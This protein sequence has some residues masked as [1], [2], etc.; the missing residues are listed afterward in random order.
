MSRLGIAKVQNLENYKER[1][2]QTKT[3]LNFRADK[4]LKL[5]VYTLIFIT[6][7]LSYILRGVRGKMSDGTE[8][9][10]MEDG[11][12]VYGIRVGTI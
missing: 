12:F 7:F 5:P 9:A 11:L 4:M 10:S 2:Q 1:A 6:A 8:Q 3:K